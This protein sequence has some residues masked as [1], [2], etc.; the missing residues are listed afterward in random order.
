MYGRRSRFK[1]F[2]II[3]IPLLVVLYLFIDHNL[4]R[5]LKEIAKSKAQLAGQEI[6][7][8]AVNEKVAL[9]TEYQD[10]VAVHKDGEGRIVLIQPNTVKINRMMAETLLE[11]E[12]GFAELEKQNY[13]IPLGQALGSRVFAGYGP[14]IKVKMIP[15]GQVSADFIDSFE[16]AGINQTRHLISLRISGKIKV[17]VPFNDEEVDVKMTIPVAETIVVGQVPQTYMMLKNQG[18]ILGLSAE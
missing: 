8:R 9:K 10:L 4:E 15:A 1:W 13:S 12:T 11:V 6:I 7:T 16:E 5:T 3:L 17:V 14:G 18:K 2:I